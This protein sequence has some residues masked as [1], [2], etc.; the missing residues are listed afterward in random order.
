MGFID[1][2]FLLI[3]ITRNLNFWVLIDYFI[4]II[5]IKIIIIIIIIYLLVNYNFLDLI[6]RLFKNI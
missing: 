3:I 5:T 4:K 1:A 2:N 6:L